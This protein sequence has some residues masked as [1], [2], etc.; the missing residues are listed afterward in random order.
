VGVARAL[1]ARA[2]EH[3]PTAGLRA[4]FIALTA[5]HGIN[6]SQPDKHR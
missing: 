5:G 6:L 3:T 2:D 4:L 1:L